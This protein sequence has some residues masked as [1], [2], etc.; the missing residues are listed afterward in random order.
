M[1]TE[2]EIREKIQAGRNFMK[3]PV[4]I[5]A[6]Y[7]TDQY[8][9]KPQPPL[10]K[11]PV[12]DVRIPLPKEFAEVVR[13][14]DFLD[15]INSRVSNRVYT[16]EPLTLKQLSYLLWCAQGVKGLR[17]KKYATL[18]TVPCGGA[19]HQFELYLAVQFVEGL[20]PGYYHYLPQT[21]ELELLSEDDGTMRDFLKESLAGQGW[22]VK[23][24][25]T[26]YISMV[27]YRAEWRYGISSHRV[28]LVDSG[29]I[30]ENIYLAA[31]AADLGSCA[32][33]A[34][35]NQICDE[36]FG[37]DGVDEYIFLAHPVGTVRPED[38][39]KEL[40]FYAFIKEFDK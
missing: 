1:Y 13:K 11:D 18:R 36:K 35:R 33:G 6:D 15:V 30:S 25:V 16:E 38:Y 34:V 22:T 4:V 39:Q 10:F 12:S 29:Y 3:M 26:F 21:H 28:A 7:K 31:T 19:R 14:N 27:A 8:L 17:G 2:E 40:D 20:K 24:S 32:I 37:L 23:A 9:G 5:D